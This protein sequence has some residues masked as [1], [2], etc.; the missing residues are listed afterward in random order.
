MVLLFRS[1]FDAIGLTWSGVNHQRL[2]VDAIVVDVMGVA[3]T[4][5]SINEWW[6]W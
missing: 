5:G 2:P 1:R 6:C 4:D 3:V